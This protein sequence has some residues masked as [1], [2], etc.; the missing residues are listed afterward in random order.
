MPGKAEN[1]RWYEGEQRLRNQMDRTYGIN[2]DFTCEDLEHR[3]NGSGVDMAPAVDAKALIDSI[4]SQMT[5]EGMTPV[6]K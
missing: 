5:F 3:R 4:G 1:L 2:M 6:G